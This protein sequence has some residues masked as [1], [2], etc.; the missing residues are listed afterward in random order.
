MPL[1]SEKAKGKQRAVE[2]PPA[3][4]T[5]TA[6]TSTS[7]NHE[8]DTRELVIRFTEGGTDLT[9]SVDK[10]DNVRDVKDKIRATR[11]ELHTRRLRLIYLGRLLTDGTFIYAWLA[12]LEEK[13]RRAATGTGDTDSDRKPSGTT[14]IHCSVGPSVETPE[15]E[16]RE[17]RSIQEGQ[18]QPARGF[19]RLASLGFSEDDIANFRRQFHSQSSLNYLDSND[20]ET[21]EQYDEHARALEEQWIDSMDS[22]SATISQ[23]ANSSN[24]S[25]LQ[26]ILLG[27]FF[28]LIPFF[29]MRSKHPA[30]FWE[31]GSEAEPI[32]NVIFSRQTQMGLVIGFLVNLMFGLWRFLLDAS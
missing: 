17:E 12:S 18:L 10:L 4:S 15:D 31:D 28:P 27:F 5:G 22:G 11:P 1:L 20:F 16:P 26:G 3:S 30:A 13:Q 29:F 8:P 19:D 25:I 7:T 6:S 32:P 2:L 21:E 23:A 9:I 24:A 14:W